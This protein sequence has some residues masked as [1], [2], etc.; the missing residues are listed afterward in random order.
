MTFRSSLLIFVC[1]LAIRAVVAAVLFAWSGE[2]GFLINDSLE[3]LG[4]AKSGTGQNQ[5]MP[6]YPLFLS[7]HLNLFGPSVV[8]PIL[9]QLIID[10]TTCVVIAHFAASIDRSLGRPAGIFAAINPA[11]IVVATLILTET[12][13]VFACALALWATVRWLRRPGWSA[14]GAIGVAIGFGIS[15]RAMLAPWAV[16]LPAVL[17]IVAVVAGRIDRK[18]VGQAVFAALLA[19]A[20]QAPV[21]FAN[22]ERFGSWGL[23]AQGGTYALH[24]LVPLVMEAKDGTPHG[25]G[26]QLMNER[27]PEAVDHANHANPFDRSRAMTRA[28]TEMLH[29]LGPEPI[30]KAWTY[31]AAINL[32]SPAVIL[33]TPVRDLPRT[34]FYATPGEGKLDKIV[35]FLFRN[36]NPTY[37]WVLLIAALGTLACRAIQLRGAW[38]WLRSGMGGNRLLLAGGLLCLAWIG[39]VLAI[40]GPVASAKYRAPL[41]PALVVLF[42]MGWSRR[43]MVAKRFTTT[44]SRL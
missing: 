11:Q 20:I 6:I 8:W 19:F 26:A 34:G 37:G 18:I 36:D 16:I 21:L 14:A 17:L 10:S 15:I 13:F 38:R 24:W 23:T 41:E 32:L 27:F 9:S 28:A 3:Y 30:A 42:A 2:S 39:F 25:E 35:A 5:F 31:G 43:P 4:L 22:H 33:T 40:N 12:L 44:P 7:A 1:A 29:E